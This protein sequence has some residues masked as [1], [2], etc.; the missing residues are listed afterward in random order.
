MDVKI[1]WKEIRTS[2]LLDD[3]RRSG[4]AGSRPRTDCARRA[5]EIGL[6]DERLCLAKSELRVPENLHRAILQAVR[7]SGASP[8]PR[9][10]KRLGWW[11]IPAVGC[12]L[13]ACCLPLL[14]SL[15]PR[16]GPA[17]PG[18]SIQ[19][20]ISSL[21][22]TLISPLSTEMTLLQRDLDRTQSFLL[23]SIPEFPNN[24]E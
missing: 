5:A 21:P 11:L 18:Q 9:N 13:L 14:R 22:G 19:Q 1:W 10:Q 17:S 2:W 15:L 8:F 20:Q 12:V 4:E 16:P 23:A 7:R 6:V 3:E 24:T